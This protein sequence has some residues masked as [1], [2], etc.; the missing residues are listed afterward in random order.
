[1]AESNIVHERRLSNYIPDINCEKRINKWCYWKGLVSIWIK[2]K[3]SQMID[4][5]LSHLLIQGFTSFYEIVRINKVLS[6][7]KSMSLHPHFEVD[8]QARLQIHCLKT[9]F[10]LFRIRPITVTMR[11]KK[12]YSIYILWVELFDLTNFFSIPYF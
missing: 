8:F 3:W 11:T 7:F 1:M 12:I 5:F 4:I 9:G 2:K 6:Y 10:D